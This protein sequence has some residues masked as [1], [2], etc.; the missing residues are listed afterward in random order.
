M[1]GHVVDVV[2]SVV[3]KEV[4]AN[5]ERG[6]SHFVWVRLDRGDTIRAGLDR[7][8]TTMPGDRVIV[9]QVET[10]LLGWR[11]YRYKKSAAVEK[12]FEAPATRKTDQGE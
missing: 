1:P 8:V 4:L 6:P 5:D 10:P 2:G 9:V 12:S 3:A 7:Y 11:R